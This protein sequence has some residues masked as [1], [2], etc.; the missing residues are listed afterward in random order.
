MV[1]LGI[2]FTTVGVASQFNLSPLLASMV[3]GFV[4]VNVERRHRDFF[5]GPERAERISPMASAGERGIRYTMHNDT[6]VTPM[7]P[8]PLIWSAV[9]RLTSSGHVLGPAQRITPTQALRAHTIDAAWQVFREDD[10]GSIEAEK[11]ADFA[12]LSK[13]PLQNAGTI[14]DIQ[15]ETTIKDGEVIFGSID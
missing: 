4:I 2:I 13:N 3:V 6:P 9:N 12:V 1:I 10:L 8:L 5:L 7:R 11:S 14:N 15:V